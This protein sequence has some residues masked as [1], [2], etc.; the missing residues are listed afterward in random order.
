MTH[1][2]GLHRPDSLVLGVVRYIWTAMEELVYAVTGVI[3]HYRTVILSRNRFS[4]RNE[5]RLV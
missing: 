2:A 4:R 1:H 3:A 5:L